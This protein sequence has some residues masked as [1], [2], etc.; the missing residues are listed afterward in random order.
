MISQ[1]NLSVLIL[2]LITISMFTSCFKK[3]E[4][5]ELK[6]CAMVMEKPNNS[7]D[8]TDEITEMVFGQIEE[9]IT[10]RN[11]LRVID[12]NRFDKV[13]E[14]MQFQQTDWASSEKTADLGKALNA[15]FICIVTIYK[16][17]YKVEF[18]NV[19]SV[20]KKTCLGRY[21]TSFISKDVKVKDLDKLIKLDLHDL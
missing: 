9:A 14:E 17:S 18:L 5:K 19:N 13:R 2:L 12:R 7:K 21:S 11:D 6:A 20:Q 3:E 10:Q 16:D 8:V 1:K 4:P 15:D